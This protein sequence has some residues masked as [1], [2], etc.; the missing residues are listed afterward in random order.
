MKFPLYFSNRIAFSKD[1]KNNLSRIIIFIGRLSVALGVIVSLITV[2]TGVGSKNAIK[3]R[4]ADFGGAIQIKSQQ[5]NSSYNS[6]VLNTEGFQ[7]EKVQNTPNVS[8]VQKFVTVSGIM[9]TEENFAGIIY[10]GVGKDF[11]SHRFAKFIV[12]GKVPV[13]TE[14]GYSNQVIL[15]EKIA[16]DLAKK[17][18]DSVVTIFS[19]EDQKPIYRKF[20]VA[21][22][23]KTD[24]K[25]IDDLFV[26][27]G[28]NHARKIQDMEKDQVGG[29]DVFLQDN[30]ALE[31]SFTAL[32][33]AIGAKNYLEKVTDKYPQIV[34]WI[35]IFD[36][37]I[38]LIITIMLVVV[39]INI[40]MVLLILI[41]ERTNSIGL[42]K[43]LGATNG[44]IRTI[45]INYT[46]LIMVPGLLFGN[47]IGIG[48][49]LLQKMTGFLK[50]DPENYYVSEVPV[51]LN[52][53][54]ILSI[55]LGILV[56]SA[57][58]LILPSYLISKI[59][60]VKAIKYT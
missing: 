57:V 49:L 16:S 18:G 9:R 8:G 4:L 19:K 21:G 38:A 54:Y 22:I 35:N 12:S 46:L 43:T 3:N 60:P 6:T 44:Q 42:L 26:I 59:S 51:D 34:D 11:D 7:I 1:N 17:V 10:K 5:S 25:L 31:E 2:S 56:V 13:V 40:I 47:L 45:F 37:N 15:S 50:L 32:Q 39:I 30:D 53:I 20:E 48:L 55:S 41:I 23:Y 27:G 28:I 29:Y 58:A 24:I 36:T 14:Q 33:K 52:P